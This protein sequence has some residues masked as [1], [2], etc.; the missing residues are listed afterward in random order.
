MIQHTFRVWGGVLIVPRLVP[1]EM[2]TSVLFKRAVESTKTHQMTMIL[3]AR[4]A[5]AILTFLAKSLF[6]KAPV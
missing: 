5:L 6:S 3:V 1:I 4:V 2:L